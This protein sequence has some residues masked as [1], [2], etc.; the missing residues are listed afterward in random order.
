M[1]YISEKVIKKHQNDYGSNNLVCK[2]FE[3][4]FETYCSNDN[5]STI[6][7]NKCKL[8]NEIFLKKCFKK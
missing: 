3:N 1:P 4:Y 2:N 7:S 5:L 6:Q 8:I